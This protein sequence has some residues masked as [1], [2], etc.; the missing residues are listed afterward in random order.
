[1]KVA[2][3]M[4]AQVEAVAPDTTVNDVSKLI[5]GRGINGVPVVKGKK[6]VGFITERDILE[7]FYPSMGEYLD[8]PIHASDFEEMEKKA[9]EI[10][11][12]TA[13]DIMSESP[14]SIEAD[15]PILRAQSLMFVNK[16]GRLPVVDKKG[17]LVGIVS[18]GDIFKAAVG[19]KLPFDQE[20]EF[21]DWLAKY[22]D[23]LIDW[24]TRLSKEIPELTDLFKKER[25]GHV[26][27]VASSTG[28]HAVA[29]AKNGF[30]VSGMEASALMHQMA[31]EKVSKLP[32]DVKKRIT[33]L[34]GLYGVS[35]HGLEKT[36]DAAIFMGNALS[37]AAITDKYILSHV[38]E[39]LNSKKGILVF[40]ILNFDKIFKTNKVLRDFTLT[41]VTAKH[42]EQHAFFGFYTKEG[43]I[44]TYTR[45]VFIL[46]EGKWSFQGIKS[47][48]VVYFGEKEITAA[49]KK[50]GFST[51]TS[52][53]SPFYGNLFQEP[54]KE[55]ESDWLNVVATR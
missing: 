15:S 42:K 1:M 33:F 37:H 18:N 10:L 41:P 26:L 11:S 23:T 21:Y 8:D 47:T 50:L 55:L 31:E 4:Q 6:I 38:A 29:L 24:D 34:P 49:L 7:K 45:A 53:G 39:R 30:M 9:G 28:E 12:L 35:M 40:Q 13:Q 25:V 22:Y 32:H 54:F 19:R 44:L 48:P 20:E 52:Y 51:I 46:S 14:V 27:D 36:I 43:T 2:D 3:V 16:V 17:N 5:F